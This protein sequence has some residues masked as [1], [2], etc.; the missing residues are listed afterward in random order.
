MMNVKRFSQSIVVLMLSAS[1]SF[2]DSISGVWLRDNGEMRVKFDQCG[3]AICGTVVW[4]KP[5]AASK[6]KIGQ[7]FFYDMRPAS[8]NSWT[9]KASPDGDSV[10]SGKLSFEGVTLTTSGC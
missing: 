3:G 2:A 10:Y 1:P 4:L 6:A 7:R 5:G 8:L 9:G